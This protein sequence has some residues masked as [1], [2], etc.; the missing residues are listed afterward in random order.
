MPIA[1]LVSA[2]PFP[3]DEFKPGLTPDR[4][5]LDPAENGALSLLYVRDSCWWLRP[6]S[7][8]PP[9]RIPVLG[10]DLAGSIV[11]D[12]IN[13]QLE[14]EPD[15]RPALFWIP[16]KK[17]AEEIRVVHQAELKKNLENQTRWFKI[18][19]IKADNDWAKL[20]NHRAVTDMSR[21]AAKALGIQRDWA[22]EPET[23]QIGAG[24]KECPACTSTI[25]ERAAICPICKC[26][27]DPAKIEQFMFAERPTGQVK[28]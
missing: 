19:I 2:V 23:L 18:L 24:G 12:Y 13:S 25:N 28:A 5:K 17:S 27:L 9:I 26:I 21:Y 16:G 3:I 20:K 1:T 11:N 10:E 22:V 14:L 4:Y 7:E 8:R 15:A 6:D